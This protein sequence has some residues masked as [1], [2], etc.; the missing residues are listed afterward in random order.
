M[1]AR[2]CWPV[3]VAMSSSSRFFKNI[4]PPPGSKSGT[5]LSRFIPREELGDVTNWNPAT[6]GERR[7]KPRSAHPAG[8]E[9][10]APEQPPQTTEA[11]WRARIATARQQG[12]EEGYRD[13]TAALEGFK[14]SH[15]R[16]ASAQLGALL[17][18]FDAQFAALDRRLAQNISQL[19][20]QLARQVLRAE[21][22]QHPAV[23]ASVAAEAVAG[24]VLS[25]RQIT[26]HVHPADLPLVAEGAEEALRGRGARL[27]PDPGLERG[28]VLVQ[29]DAGCVDGRIEA[30]WAQ[31]AASLGAPTPW[32]AVGESA[33]EAADPD[34]APRRGPRDE[35]HDEP[36]ETQF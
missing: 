15:Q 27:V 33:D 26:V 16:E 13:G 32:A 21:L 14:L 11:E 12:Y 18:G 4:P 6:F 30:R 24:V 22:Q 7:Q 29:S 25:A 17:E 36:T 5:P 31:A 19:A 9:Q 10:S 35:R 23:V 28:G 20:V 3:G 34:A 8:H 2:S 1:K